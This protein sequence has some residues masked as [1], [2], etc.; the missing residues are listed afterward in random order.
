MTLEQ[1]VYFH[2]YLMTIIIIAIVVVGYFIVSASLGKG[3]S[4]RTIADHLVERI[5]T[6]LPITVLILSVH[7]P[8][9]L[10]YL[11]D[12]NRVDFVCTLKVIGHQRH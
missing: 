12:E 4:P 10:L 2:D 11:I 1:T 7:P 6:I 8:I 5:R 9:Y 3:Y